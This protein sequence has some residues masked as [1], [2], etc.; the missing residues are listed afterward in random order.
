MAFGVRNDNPPMSRSKSR[1]LGV[2][3][4]GCAAVLGAMD[5]M[6]WRESGRIWVLGT[7]IIPIGA[8]LGP[9]W[10][11]VGRPADPATGRVPRWIVL[12]EAI[13]T[14]VALAVGLGMVGWWMGW[15]RP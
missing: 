5:V 9:W 8:L 4:L 14:V 11:I 2:L 12:G 7:T 13:V 15:I 10:L 3:L 1:K 6:E